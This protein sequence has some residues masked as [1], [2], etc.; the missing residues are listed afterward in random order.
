MISGLITGVPAA[1]MQ[2]ACYFRNIVT[3]YSVAI[4]GWPPRIPF[5]NLSTVS[6]ALPDLEA[7]L[8]M[9][10]S[11]A[12]FW[13]KLSN[14]YTALRSERDAKLNSGEF[15]EHTR[16]TRSDKGTKQSHKKSRRGFKSL[17][18]VPTDTE[19]K[20][21]SRSSP[22]TTTN[23]PTT[24]TSTNTVD[25][26]SSTSARIINGP[27][28]HS[29]PEQTGSSPQVPESLTPHLASPQVPESSAPRSPSL[30]IP[31]I[32]LELALRNLDQNYGTMWT[33]H[34]EDGFA[35]DFRGN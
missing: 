8:R 15:I 29:A 14:E 21:N 25:T 9:W 3:R 17:D 32:D 23:T 7:L 35:F 16:K 33:Q 11:G 18:T 5:K 24:S 12:I 22:A 13:K 2:W 30:Q 4:E 19:D 26:T 20:D 31:K 28:P 34:E 6:S 10:E 1:K 27:V